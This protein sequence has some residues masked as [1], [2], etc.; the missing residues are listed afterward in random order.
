MEF[1]DEVID[2]QTDQVAFKF[3]PTGGLPNE[4]IVEIELYEGDFYA[5]KFFK[6]I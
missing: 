3:K 5:L 2:I 4:V 6:Q 1:I